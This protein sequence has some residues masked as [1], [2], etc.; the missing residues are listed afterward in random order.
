[1]RLPYLTSWHAC[2]ET[3]S[4]RR[5]RK[6]LRTTAESNEKVN[7][8]RHDVR[9]GDEWGLTAVEAN[10]RGLACVVG[11]DDA[12]RLFAPFTLQHTARPVSTTQW[13]RPITFNPGKAD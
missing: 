2:T 3:M 5:T 1:M 13:A 6:L 8:D 9:Q 12:D 4:P 10:L 7:R 11:E